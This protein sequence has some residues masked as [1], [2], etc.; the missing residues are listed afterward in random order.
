MIYLCR[1]PHPAEKS[2]TSIA[3]KV[4]IAWIV[5]KRPSTL[6]VQGY[7]SFID[8]NPNRNIIDKVYCMGSGYVQSTQV[9]RIL[10]AYTYSGSAAS[11]YFL[12][13]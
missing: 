2:C 9:V 10:P 11:A 4:E 6:Y 5:P 8:L 1:R 3:R 7:I 12:H 13:G